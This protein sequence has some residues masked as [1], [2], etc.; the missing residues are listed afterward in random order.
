[1]QA[2]VCKD[3][4]KAALRCHYLMVEV[5][6]HSRAIQGK[7]VVTP[8]LWTEVRELARLA[9]LGLILARE[10]TNFFLAHGWLIA[11]A[12][13]KPSNYG[14]HNPTHDF[15]LRANTG[16]ASLLRLQWD[17]GGVVAVGQP[18]KGSSGKG[19]LQ[20]TTCRS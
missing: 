20:L 2:F 11:A 18:R 17:A 10:D 13:E 8:R 19:V 5:A 4:D 7:L 14:C 15:I 9:L 12:G 16:S 1:M 6:K 3:A